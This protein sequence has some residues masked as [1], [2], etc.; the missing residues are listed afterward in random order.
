MVTR[1]ALETTL[2]M[3]KDDMN[4]LAYRNFSVSGVSCYKLYN[5][6]EEGSQVLILADL[7]WQE[8][9]Q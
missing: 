6:Y 2:T 4:L 8:M 1:A 7:A 9:V 3:D 5:I